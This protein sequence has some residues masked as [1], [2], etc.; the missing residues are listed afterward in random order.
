MII[1]EKYLF[2]FFPKAHPTLLSTTIRF[3]ETLIFS[4]QLLNEARVIKVMT[5]TGDKTKTAFMV[6][7]SS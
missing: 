2:V 5:G 3:F 1:I 4:T 7:L 6:L